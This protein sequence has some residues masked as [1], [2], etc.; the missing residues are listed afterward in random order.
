MK[1][2]PNVWSAYLPSKI[3]L[4]FFKSSQ[5]IY[6]VY[7]GNFARMEMECRMQVNGKNY[8]KLF[9]PNPHATP[10][11]TSQ[12]TFSPTFERK[13]TIKLLE[14]FCEIILQNFGRN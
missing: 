6:L 9:Q 11:R 12:K 3:F 2:P 5:H 7:E 13:P 8:L 14:P 4:Y 1:L 10:K